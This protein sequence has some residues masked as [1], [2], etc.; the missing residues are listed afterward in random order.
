MPNIIDLLASS[1]FQGGLVFF[2]FAILAWASVRFDAFER[3]EW[4][5]YGSILVFV[6]M[7]WMIENTTLTVP[8]LIHEGVNPYE[9]GQIERLGNEPDLVLDADRTRKRLFLSLAF[10]F[11]VL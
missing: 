3:F 6:V 2:A 10:G 1:I 7:F 9:P 4:R 8:A 5:F 11:E